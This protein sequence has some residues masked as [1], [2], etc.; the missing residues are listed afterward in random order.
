MDEDEKV[1]KGRS[2]INKIRQLALKEVNADNVEILKV[3]TLTEIHDQLSW[4]ALGVK[5]NIAM[6]LV[7]FIGTIIVFG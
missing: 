4:L 5:I 3:V 7:G 1:W 6:I 2:N